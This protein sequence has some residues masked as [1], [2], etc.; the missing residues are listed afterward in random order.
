MNFC[1]TS[2]TVGL[3]AFHRSPRSEFFSGVSVAG[4]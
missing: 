1:S 3:I 4:R 2:A